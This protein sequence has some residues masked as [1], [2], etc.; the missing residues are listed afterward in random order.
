MT[1]LARCVLGLAA[2]GSG[3]SLLIAAD[4]G[5]APWDVFHQ[6]VSRRTGIALGTVIMA[7]G[8]ALMLLW[9]PLR[10]RPGW[11][12]VLNTIEIGLVV[13]LLEPRLGTFETPWARLGALA[14]GVLAVAIGSGLYI[15]AGLG[16]GPRDGL[17]MGLERLGWSL[18][19]ARTS[20]E[21]TVLIGGWALGGSVGLGTVVFAVGIGPLVH[22]TVPRLRVVSTDSARA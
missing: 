18:R 17:M 4:L 14:A 8:A 12:T 19:G 16:A 10:E 1:R 13:N 11:G 7:V 20:I 2:F 5:L 3:I 22:R 6:G 9:W 21:L 15:G